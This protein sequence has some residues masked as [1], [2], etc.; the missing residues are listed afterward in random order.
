MGEIIIFARYKVHF[1]IKHENMLKD[2]SNNKSIPEMQ[3]EQVLSLRPQGFG[4]TRE[5]TDVCAHLISNYPYLFDVDM[6]V[7]F[8]ILSSFLSYLL[9]TF[10]SSNLFSIF[11]SIN[12]YLAICFLSLFPKHKKTIYYAYCRITSC[13]LFLR[14][15]S[16]LQNSFS[17]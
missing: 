4:E 3:S 2:P 12:F 6:E 14:W 17:L 8:Y 5:E 9:F 1:N 13:H 16:W 15:T 10:L 11:L 7:S